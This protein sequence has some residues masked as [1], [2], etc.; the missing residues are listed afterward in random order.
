VGYS[1]CRIS[2][3]L[4]EESTGNQL[5]FLREING[6]RS[7]AIG[8]GPLEALA[9]QRA[10]Q[11]EAFP[12]PLTHDFCMAMLGAFSITLVEVRI[13]RLEHDTFFAEVDL[14]GPGGRRVTIDCR[15]SDAL[16]LMVRGSEVP[17][18]VNDDILAAL[19]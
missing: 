3:L 9:I 14:T 18:R 19:G 5:V 4:I 2:H 7:F 11:G 12:R 17:L 16:A 13:V 6:D 8:I 1:P 15:P 10:L